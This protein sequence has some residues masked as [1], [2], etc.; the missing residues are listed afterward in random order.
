MTLSFPAFL[1]ELVSKTWLYSGNNV[2]YPAA[3]HQNQAEIRLY[4]VTNG[5][6]RKSNEDILATSNF[7]EG[8]LHQAPL[9]WAEIYFRNSVLHATLTTF[10]VSVKWVVRSFRLRISQ[11]FVTSSFLLCA[12][13][14]QKVWI[15]IPLQCRYPVKFHRKHTEIIPY[16]ATY[17]TKNRVE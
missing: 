11:N 2:N 15:S 12:D 8:F 14:L 4:S 7:W 17:G 9:Q 6:L 10:H 1:S 13:Q 5:I 3:F 16:S